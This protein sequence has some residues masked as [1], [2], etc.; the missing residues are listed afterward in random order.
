M[1]A[2][3]VSAVGYSG[4]NCMESAF[5]TQHS[6]YREMVCLIMECAMVWALVS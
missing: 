4:K 5:S 6:R 2:L 1:D 3:E